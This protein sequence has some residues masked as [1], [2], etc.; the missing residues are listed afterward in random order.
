MS[1]D[2]LS[3]LLLVSVT[4]AAFAL[5]VKELAGPR[6]GDLGKLLRQAAHALAKHAESEPKPVNSHLIGA[7]GEVVGHSDDAAR[8]MRIRLGMEGW[9]ARLESADRAP[10]PIGARV[11]VTAFDG[12]VAIVVPSR[13]GDAEQLA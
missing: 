13:A 1:L 4:V 9:P 6:L 7:T 8:P 12:P 10:L 3:G 11:E 2:V 5:I